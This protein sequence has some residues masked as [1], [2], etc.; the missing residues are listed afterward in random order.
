MIF[1]NLGRLGPPVSMIGLGCNSFGSRI[2]LQAARC[3]I[4][5]ALD[6]GVTFFDT[7][8]R[9]GKA[10][11]SEA[12]LGQVLSTRRKDVFVATK[13]GLP[14]DEQGALKGASQAY[15]SAAAAASL[16]RLKTDYIDLYQLHFPDPSTPLEE[17]LRALHDLVEDGKVRF[18]GCSNLPASEV[19]EAQRITRRLELNAFVS[20]QDEYNILMRNI[21]NE[22]I[23]AIQE[24]GLGLLPYFP[25]ASGLLTGKYKR[26]DPLPKDSRFS[27]WRKLADRYLTDAN[28]TIVERLEAFCLERSRS[29]LELAV[30]WLAS[31]HIV[32][33][34]IAGATRP[35]QVEQNAKACN[36]K[37]SPQD[38]RD[39]DSIIRLPSSSKRIEST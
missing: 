16:R 7:A 31:H 24:H 30:S 14:M 1:R 32:S 15:I 9:Y 27:T 21:E 10:G 36:W 18:I 38:L 28:F 12:I 22:L 17:T 3:V 39:I 26:N 29:L 8:D 20:C 25:L 23:P 19:A 11:G 5:K 37:L 13:F 2:D 35:D 34:V 6:E 4:H 33:S